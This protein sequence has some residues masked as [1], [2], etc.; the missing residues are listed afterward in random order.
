MWPGSNDISKLWIVARVTV[1]KAL[2]KNLV[3]NHLLCPRRH[4]Y[5]LRVRILG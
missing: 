1:A 4:I 3:P 5:L 2:R